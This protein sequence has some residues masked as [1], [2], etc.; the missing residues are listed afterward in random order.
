MSSELVDG[1]E[2]S[3]DV[4]LLDIRARCKELKK[5]KEMLKD[6]KSQSFEFIRSLEMHVKTLSDAHAEDKKHIQGLE[7]E[8]SN[9]SQE[10]DFLQDQLNTRNSEVNCL[11]EEICS[12]QLKLA[13]MEILEEEVERL[14]ECVKI[15][16]SEKSFLMHEI[17]DKAVELTNSNLCIEKLEES[18][19]SVGLEYQCEIE[20]MK[21]DLL[22]LEQNLFETK[23][24]LEE[25]TQENSRMNELIQEHELRFQ[26]AEKVIV[27]LDKENKDL[28]E[29]LKTFDENAK[30]FVHEVEEKFRE[31]LVKDDVHALSNLEKDTRTCGNILGPLLA[32]LA[33]PG[34]SDADLKNRMDEMLHQID[35]YEGVVTQ[36]KEELRMERFKAKEEAEDLAQEMAELRYQ[37]TGMLE[38]ERKRR[39]YVEHISLQRISEL[40]AQ[41]AKERQKSFNSQELAVRH[42]HEV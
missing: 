9:C 21:L 36:L 23:K 42:I 14:R 29:K 11:G 24:T 39:A 19:S 16:E 10:I 4:E 22:A 7:R 35:E 3:F 13:D 17:E 40:E 31:W 32:K 30:S 5:E 27:S 12:L 6:S 8:L 25:R 2:S 41:I 38:E 26:E 20:T 1:G 15:T 37:M 34:A 28:K 18:I 33:I